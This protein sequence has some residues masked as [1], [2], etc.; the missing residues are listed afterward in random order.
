MATFM[1]C[2]FTLHFDFD[3]VSDFASARTTIVNYVNGKPDGSIFNMTS[4]ENSIT[5][6]I[7]SIA[8]LSIVLTTRAD[9]LTTLTQI[10]NAKVTLPGLAKFNGSRSTLVYREIDTDE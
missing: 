3:T 8:E 7:R 2:E 6:K 9:I 4:K 5:G 1:T 10:D